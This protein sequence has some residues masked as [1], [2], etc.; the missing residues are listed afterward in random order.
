MHNA[1]MTIITPDKIIGENMIEVGKRIALSTPPLY[2]NGTDKPTLVSSSILIKWK[3]NHFLVTSGHTLRQF[4]PTELGLIFN[5]TFLIIGGY[6]GTSNSEKIE[7]DKIDIGFFHL[8]EEFLEQLSGAFQFHDLESFDF[9]HEDTEGDDYFIVG[10]PITRTKVRPDKNKIF[11][12]PFLFRTKLNKDAKLYQKTKTRQ[13]SNFLLDYRRKKI[14]N[15]LPDTIVTG[16][17]PNGLSGCGVWITSDPLTHDVNEIKYYPTGII[18][19][20]Y[21][22]H[23]LLIG[24]RMR[25]ITEVL[26]QTYDNSIPTSNRIKVNIK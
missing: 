23:N 17:E 13:I 26:R 8:S 18:I 7:D 5:K 21:K 4:K 16:P 19:E 24:T 9:D 20:Y 14:K 11:L 10:Y 6:H 2:I 3:T 12:S 25:I 1:T 22:E 15:L